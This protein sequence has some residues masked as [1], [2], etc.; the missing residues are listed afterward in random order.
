MKWESE[1]D[2]KKSQTIIAREDVRSTS[3]GSIKNILSIPQPPFA[4]THPLPTSPGISV[5]LA[6]KR[7]RLRK[8]LLSRR[9]ERESFTKKIQVLYRIYQTY[10]KRK[11]T[12]GK[13]RDKNTRKPIITKWRKQSY[14]RRKRKDEKPSGRK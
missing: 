8:L 5:L 12:N 14:R 9:R 2:T 6:I 7:R 1:T 13:K 3:L 10:E 11:Y 4:T